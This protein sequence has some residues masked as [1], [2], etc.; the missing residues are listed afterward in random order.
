MATVSGVLNADQI[1][2][3]IQQA[4]TAYQAPANALQAQ[5]KPVAAQISA[6]GK[7]QGVLSGLQSALAGL[8]NVQTLGQRSVT[9]SPSDAVTAKVTNDAAAGTYNLSGIHL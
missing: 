1:T 9:T 8:A 3:L 7:V 6:L 4:S 2:S 5:E